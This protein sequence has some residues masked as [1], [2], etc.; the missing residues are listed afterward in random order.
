MNG[1]EVQFTDLAASGECGEALAAQDNHVISALE[2][3]FRVEIDGDQL[4]TRVSG[5]EGLVYRAEG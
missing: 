1:A 2:G 4:T 3:G 5:D